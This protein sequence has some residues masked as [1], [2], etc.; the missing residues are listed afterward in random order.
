M[1]RRVFAKPGTCITDTAVQQRGLG[2]L[3]VHHLG[4]SQSERIVW[5]CEELGVPYELKIYDRDPVTR[6]APPAYR[7]L[8]PLGT[9]PIVHDDDLVLAE[10]TAIMEYIMAKH[11][12]GSLVPAST[13]ASFPAYLYW[14]HFANGTLQPN[15]GRGMLLNRV[16]LPEDN[17]TL[18]W[19]NSRRNLALS[20]VENRLGEADYL[21]G[22]VFTA[23]DI[24]TVFSLTTMRLFAPLDLS[25]YPNILSYLQRIGARDA[26]RRAMKK[27]DPEMTPMLT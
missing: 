18:N 1:V 23:A 13:D 17:P 21:A 15:L 12:S 19:V 10:S 14:F 5:L 24:V 7:A 6:L 8:H 2:M 27:G 22:D 11:G 20:L 3:T 4:K 9:A 25:P 16:G 26:Y